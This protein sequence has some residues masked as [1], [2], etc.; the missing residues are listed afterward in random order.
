MRF[1]DLLRHRRTVRVVLAVSAAAL[2]TVVL[3]TVG[4]VAF[5]REPVVTTADTV[6]ATDQNGNGVPDAFENGVFGLDPVGTRAL[7]DHQLPE[8]WI[9]RWGLDISDPALSERPAAWPAPADLPPAYGKAGLPQAFQM[10]LYDV[11]S[12]QKPAR[13]N[14]TRDGAWDSG[15]DPRTAYYGSENVPYAW[16]IHF[17]LDPRDPLVLDRVAPGAQVGLT[18]REAFEQGV[19]PIATDSDG[20]GLSDARERA[21]GLDPFRF[22]TGG[23]GIADGWFVTHGFEPLDGTVAFADPDH[24]G[25]DNL[26]EFEASLARDRNA[27]L[28]GGGLDPERLSTGGSGL[29]DGWL[30]RYGLD[31]FDAHVATTVTKE[32]AAPNGTTLRLTARDEYAVNRP[33]LWNESRNGPWLGGT[34]PTTNDTDGDGLP[35]V[36]E[37][38]GWNETTPEGNRTVHS[39]P[40][41]ADS[42]SDGI[43]DAQESEGRVGN[44]TFPPT[45]PLTADTDSDG[46]TDGQELG[47]VPFDGRVLPI[48]DPTDPDTPHQGLMDGEA[49]QFWV[50]RYRS[51]VAQEPYPW[52]AAAPRATLEALFASS[53]V[54][55]CDRL[56][57]DGHLRE[58]G[59]PNILEPDVDGDGLL[60]GWEIH[61]EKYADSPYA[62]AALRSRTDPANADTDGD[63]LPDGWE[64]RNAIHIERESIWNLDAAKWSSFGDNVSDGERDLDNDSITWY[65]YHREAS[66]IAVHEHHFKCTNLVEFE[67]SSDPNR[68]SSSPDGLSDGWKIFWGRVYGGLSPEERG[69][70]YPGAPGDLVLPPDRSAPQ[71]GHDDTSVWRTSTYTRYSA[72]NETLTLPGET[73]TTKNVV[74]VSGESRVIREIRGTSTYGPREAAA[75]G[76]NPYL[77]DTDGDGVPDWWEAIWSRLGTPTARV[78]PVVVD[79]ARDFDG[80]LLSNSREFALG[81]DPYHADSDLG[82]VH[83]DLE[84]KLHLD[85]LDP[86]D[87]ALAVDSSMDTDKDGLSDNAELL[88]VTG[89]STSPS[90][91]DTDHDGIL[92]GHRL[93]RVLGRALHASDAADEQLL[94]ALSARGIFIVHGSDGT[95]DALGELD[96]GSDPTRVS[97]AGDGIP[98]GWKVARGLV[99]G[100]PQPDLFPDYAYGRPDWWNESRMGVWWWGLAPHATATRDEDH[101]GLDDLNGEDP[102]PVANAANVLP[103]GD[104]QAPEIS[105]DEALLRGQGYAGQTVPELPA[106]GIAT[107]VALDPAPASILANGS[108]VMTGNVTTERGS[109]VPNATVILSLETRDVQVGVAITAN[110]G[111]FRMPILVAR[112]L[113]A[114]IASEG[115][116][117]FGRDD[118]KGRHENPVGGLEDLRGANASIFAWTYNISLRSPP[119]QADMLNRS[120][121]GVGVLHGNESAPVRTILTLP[122]SVTVHVD[123]P[124]ARGEPFM[125]HARLTD[126]LGRPVAARDLQLADANGTAT[127]DANGTAAFPFE[128]DS[129]GLHALNVA[130]G[131]ADGLAPSMGEAIV[132]VQSHTVLTLNAPPSVPNIGSSFAIQSELMSGPWPVDNALVTVTCIGPRAVGTT[133]RAG[134]VLAIFTS[135]DDATAGPLTCIGTFAGND[136]LAPATARLEIVLRGRPTIHAN[137]IILPAGHAGVLE[138]TLF[139]SRGLPLTDRVVEMA[140]PEGRALRVTT[141]SSG[142]ASFALSSTVPSER[143]VVLRFTDPIDGSASRA[144][145]VRAITPTHVTLEIASIAR[146]RPAPFAGTV[147]DGGGRA[148]GQRAVHV[149]VAGARV[150][151]VTDAAGKFAGAITLDASA[152]LGDGIAT[153]IFDGSPD[154]I[155]LRNAT[156]VSTVI[157]DAPQLDG[158]GDVIHLP[159]SV[160]SGRITTLLGAPLARLD[161]TLSGAWGTTTTLTLPDG[162][163]RVPIVVPNSVQLGGLQVSVTTRG[164][165]TLAVLSTTVPMHLTSSATLSLDVPSRAS[166]AATLS[167]IFHVVDVR[168]VVV[169]NASLAMSVDGTPLA[170]T[171]EHDVI[172]AS[173][174]GIE[175]GPRALVVRI[176]SNDA[177]A[178]PWEETLHIRSATHLALASMPPVTFGTVSEA[179]VHVE[180]AAVDGPVRLSVRAEDG[181]IREVPT[182]ANGDAHITLRSTDPRAARWSVLFA[183]DDQNAPATLDLVM[184]PVGA[185]V[186]RTLFPWLVPLAIVAS[187][188][189]AAWYLRGA[190]EDTAQLRRVARRL[191]SSRADVRALYAAYLDILK[192]CGRSEGDVESLT[193]GHLGQAMLARWPHA[194]VEVQA[195]VDAFNTGLYAEGMARA[196]SPARIAAAA[197]ERLAARGSDEG[198]IAGG[199]PQGGTR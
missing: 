190:K 75:L 111:S 138:A 42:D 114:P 97:S 48:L 196:P 158:M 32:W 38:V 60:N 10:T 174:A 45:D 57:P 170:V 109:P 120:F 147:V 51:C 198:R 52:V 58:K 162:T 184:R 17:G 28:S 195:I 85:P 148:V 20:D 96:F 156:S 172:H 133:D 116:P 124:V 84:A 88:G 41:R 161:V 144:V 66:G 173:L 67:S 126:G 132:D 185:E 95:A 30:V 64:T 25:L 36:V 108:F 87:D 83:D 166:R 54:A 65:S 22:S 176:V 167:G 128:L 106:D 1:A 86:H 27:T 14:E 142:R 159:N 49:A 107:V 141:D 79:G 34:D 155:Y 157:Q 104:P 180:R 199:V 53:D 35:D 171:I 143:T 117:V 24:D 100:A 140:D 81:A 123:A 18:P 150:T 89:H 46:L 149:D 189:L 102:I 40:T 11:Y 93:S 112:E 192:L 146:G 9:Q 113:S 80:D 33:P 160:L 37:I 137:D 121:P 110:D 164:A 94:K 4:A 15:I 119:S 169:P 47:L 92:D 186:P 103:L 76:T 55:L 91:P 29:P 115:I 194:T 163:F 16:L 179:I 168:G 44:L 59:T 145:T 151:V 191:R 188:A 197:I 77:D 63:G 78:D 2:A 50:E 6:I 105:G 71:V 127:T 178:P 69:D 39:D 13:W 175:P 8:R 152:A 74:I 139:D 135:D 136:T 125:I 98:D 165:P 177:T 122:T 183:G 118:G 72:A 56:L 68:M 23:T 101:D 3:L 12:Y 5:S 21:R 187:V 90:D 134:R 99:P 130:F 19:G 7:G 182:D 61:P 131:G 26:H 70:L 153:A 181:S 193:L 154:G 129:A 31:P 43:T 73:V 62:S 82:G